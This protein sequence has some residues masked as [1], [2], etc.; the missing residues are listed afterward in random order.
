MAPKAGKKTTGKKTGKKVAPKAK[1]V[2]KKGTKKK[3]STK[4]KKAT[5]KKVAPKKE[6]VVKP[7]K[8]SFEGKTVAPKGAYL[9][10]SE[11]LNNFCVETTLTKKEAKMCFEALT[12]IGQ[13]EL[14]KR[15]KFVIPGM[16][17][18]V[19]KKKPAT[20]ARK[21][22]NPFTKEPCVFAAKPARKVVKAFVVKQFKEL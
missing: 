6:K 3:P 8:K 10:K 19:V 9:T 22:I 5:G 12:N 1:K 4:T 16:S 13:T 7:V 21:G 17:R 11:L 18:F 15:G 2:V 14:Q 20:K